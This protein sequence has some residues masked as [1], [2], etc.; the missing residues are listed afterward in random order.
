M[1][2]LLKQLSAQYDHILIDSPPALLVSD[3]AVLGRL[4]GACFLVA[5]EG[6]STLGEVEEAHK[7][8]A[9]S[10]VQVKGVL[11]NDIQPRANRYGSK[12][13]Y[14]YSHYR[15]AQNS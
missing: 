15:Y 6:Q 1:P 4:V 10:G 5:R 11:Y 9:Q 7:R 2:A 12:Y 3:A 8:L 13:S 14:R